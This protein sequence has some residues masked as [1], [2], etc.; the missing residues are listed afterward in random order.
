MFKSSFLLAGAITILAPCPVVPQDTQPA[1]TSSESRFSD[2]F[3]SF[4]WL[5][6]EWQGYGEFSDRVTFIHKSYAYE[7]G[8][9]FLVERT[10]DMFPPPEPSTDFEV[11][12]DLSVLHRDNQTG[13][14]TATTFFVETYVTTA[15]VRV[16]EDGQSFVVESTSIQNAPPGM[17]TRMTYRRLGPDRFALHFEL[18]LPGQ[19]YSTMEE[20]R[21]KRIR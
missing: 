1:G 12:Q 17:R 2:R 15:A 5:I 4:D 19:E 8:G 3:E 11:H 18:A 10:L 16:L 21:F 9:V 7:V 6:G 13:E 14:F 20:S